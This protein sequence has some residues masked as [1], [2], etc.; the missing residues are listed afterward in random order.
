MPIG[1]ETLGAGTLGGLALSRPRA[2]PDLALDVEIETPDGFFRLPTDSR[3][4]ADKPQ[5]LSFGTQRGDGFGPGAYRLTRD[6]F[7]NFP[8]L[9]LLDTHRLV[10]HDGEI[11]YEGKLHS[12][13]RGNNPKG[14]QLDLVGW[15]TYLK[16]RPI[17]PLV[18]DGRTS[19]WTDPS[20]QRRANLIS[21]KVRLDA[22]VSTGWQ[23]EGDAGP[24]VT[25]DF[26]GITTV[27]E[28]QDRGESWFYGGGQDIAKLLYHFVKLAGASGEEW[29]T[30][31]V[32]S[33]DD[34][35]SA[36]NGGTDH[37][38]ATNSSEYETLE[39]TEAG[40][41]YAKL[42]SARS[43]DATGTALADLHNW[44]YPKVIG[45]HWLTLAGSWP[46]VGFRLTD[47]MEW[48]VAN[49]Y[50]KITWAGQEN[51]FV[52]TQAA[53]QDSPGYGY[54]ILQQLGELALWELGV[55][56]ER[57]LYF[58]PADLTTYDWQI[59][60]TDPGVEVLFQGD[61]IENF[62]NGI[63]VTYTDIISQQ[64]R[65][66]YPDENSELLDESESNPANRHGEDL[67]VQTDLPWPGTEAEAVQYARAYL[68]EYLRPKRP[69]TY[70]ISGGY[71]E[72]FAEHWHQG[73]K[74]RSSQ[75]LGILDHPDDAP[76][77]IFETQWDQDSKTLDI[78]VDAPS[79]F[80][81]AVVAR[82]GKARETRGV[83]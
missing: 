47:I 57:K 8:D 36:W 38:A 14:I 24:G 29:L 71:I 43:A 25:M 32:L 53:Y 59:R 83:A 9:N 1:S 70:R 34:V 18:I 27:D 12:E 56:E 40:R 51:P 76:R 79:M 22:S 48:L 4:A 15:A 31:A 39:A 52:V 21:S 80:L 74:V 61:S 2:K 16:S 37:H 13:P 45:N 23:D 72:D 63:A 68:A 19:S 82:I 10:G 67:W 58:E 11:A 41:K 35:L 75:T 77:L 81:P 55:W 30:Q 5:D 50:P 17:N 78:T 3:K 7:R 69:G 66:I 42:A 62:A 26:N 73:W 46:E 54:D 65:T 44:A 49:F 33:S 60:T 64:T 20:T 6:I 28:Y